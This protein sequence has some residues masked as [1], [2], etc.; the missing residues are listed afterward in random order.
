MKKTEILEEKWFSFRRTYCAEG[1]LDTWC[2]PETDNPNNDDASE[3][4][5]VMLSTYYRLNGAGEWFHRRE[6][7][8]ISYVITHESVEISAD[9]IWKKTKR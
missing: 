6:F 2:G 8:D 9:E 7:E 3:D 5:S 1:F 4:D